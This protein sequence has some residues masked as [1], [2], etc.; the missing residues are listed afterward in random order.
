V[1]TQPEGHGSRV[2]RGRRGECA[3]LDRVL[4][5][6]RHGRSGVLVIRG[7]PGVGKSALLEYVSDAVSDFRVARAVG[8]DSEM[9]LAFAGLHQLCGPLLDRLDRLPPPQ[10]DALG[11]A[12][13]LSTGQGHDRFLLG[14]AVLT[15][16]SEVAAERPLVA[17]IDDAQW[18]DRASLA[19]LA[20]VARRLYA[21][22]VALI[23]ATREL[24]DELSG[25]PELVV[26]GLQ[27]RDARALLGTV[28]A[29]PL[30][31][32]VRERIL[33]ETRGN[34]L[35]LLELPRGL[36]APELAGGFA[37][38]AAP[39]SGRIEASFRQRFEQL[40]ADT[41]RLVLAAAAEPVGDA[42]LLW[43]ACAS[44]GI[45]A[46]VAAPAEAAGLFRIDGRVT[47]S[48][49]LVRSAVYRGAD[50]DERRAVHRALAE[51][52]DPEQDPDRRA[53][54]RAEAETGPD[55]DVAAELERSAGRA[56][57]RGGLAAAA[58]F[59]ERSTA[60]TANQT[61]RAERALAAAQAK[62]E[63]GAPDAARRLL[64][65]VELGPLDDLQR[66]RVERMRARLAFAE[67]RGADALPLLLRAARRLEPLDA[68]LARET[69]AE[70]LGAALTTGHRESM[71]AA[72]QAL[73]AAPPPA[74]AAE[75]VLTGQALRLTE[76]PAAGVPVLRRALDAFRSEPLS[77]EDELRGLGYACSVALNLWDDE[78]WQVLSARHVTLAREAGALTILPQ[79]LEMHAASLVISGDFAGAQTLA[80]EGEAIAGAVGS[81]APTDAAT[82][83]AGWRGDETAALGR[84]ATA[85]DDAADRGEESSVTIAEYAAAI[86]Y[87]GLGR[88]EQ[89]MAAAQR[90]S[91]HHPAGS[92]ALALVE[93]VEGAV[94]SGDA[95]PAPAALD[96]LHTA[97][98]ASGT[99]WGRGVEAR[100]RALLLNGEEAEA[101]HRE[102]IE[103]LARTRS[104]TDLARA[105]LLYGE[106]LRRGRRR[107]DG[108][109]QLRTAHEL[110]AGMGAEAFA[111]RAA[112]ELHATGETARK[113]SV[114]TAGEL[115]AQ[116]VQVAR[117]AR[118]GLSN[119]EIGARLFISPRTVQ[120]H[121][122]KV[123]GKLDISSR[124]QLEFVLPPELV[125]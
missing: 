114:E 42:A 60:L 100:T 44:L 29:G 70:A 79:A 57:A 101:A 32:R 116:E 95:A 87:N 43:R 55:E 94:R 63:A 24:S 115:T 51:A 110:F 23:L 13:G 16:L 41:R 91:E 117:L 88:H 75:L 26:E 112:R 92:F 96:L 109:A 7:E 31:E 50:P 8:V 78:S 34:P 84:I 74:R 111:D 21:E 59:L 71:E 93:L 125:P 107:L 9:E 119:P 12:F 89:A 40:P 47:F 66:A 69:Y 105:H 82:M 123:F 1:A 124:S 14:L 35:A 37:L 18:L 72:S 67:R 33:A 62:Y 46:E 11:T 64:E 3:A 36:T 122:R 27:E 56:R 90:A 103:R 48:H 10:R 39:L 5:E 73:R 52:T 49:P 28:M 108:R 120:Y 99:D 30:D 54:H 53:W 68:T 77:G 113:R 98:A 22:S 58:A 97:T 121:L 15:L 17:L 2:L 81:A 45:G 106:W 83:L 80:D 4:D 20:F 118:D 38:P 6:L 19:T 65:I 61:R 104:R 85:I 76:G 86:L 25:L 102:A